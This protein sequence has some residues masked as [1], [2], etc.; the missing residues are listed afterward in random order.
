[1]DSK[2]KLFELEK[3]LK[4]WFTDEALETIAKTTGFVKRSSSRLSA[5]EFFNLVT[6]DIFNSSDSFLK[7]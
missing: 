1:M 5:K 2:N 4:T 6:V 3:E 7:Q